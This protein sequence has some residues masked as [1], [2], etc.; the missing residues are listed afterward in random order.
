VYVR[1]SLEVCEARDPR[2][3]YQAARSGGIADFTGISAPYEA[4]LEPELVLDTEEHGVDELVD[5]VVQRLRLE[6]LV[7]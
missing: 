6:H 7:R 4:P 3:L 1:A 2:G 5:R